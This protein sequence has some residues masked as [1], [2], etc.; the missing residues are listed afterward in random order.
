MPCFTSC[1]A[2]N[3]VLALGYLLN[4]KN[5]FL[6]VQSTFLYDIIKWS[7]LWYD[8]FYDHDLWSWYFRSF[9]WSWSFLKI[10]LM[11]MMFDLEILWSLRWSW[12]LILKFLDHFDDHDLWSYSLQITLM[13][14]IFDLDHQK[15]DLTHLC[16]QH[17]LQSSREWLASKSRLFFRLS[18][19]PMFISSYL[20]YV[21]LCVAM[22][23]V[24]SVSCTRGLIRG[25]T[26]NV[27]LVTNL[28]HITRDWFCDS[29]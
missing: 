3:K 12:S 25:E 16:L 10:I 19:L 18:A 22:W 13:I 11:I 5:T 24:P 7:D 17:T 14:L 9:W 29:N 8:H 6:I 1:D 27:H 4:A 15:S 2:Y 23:Q 28:V 20:G 26:V 21:C